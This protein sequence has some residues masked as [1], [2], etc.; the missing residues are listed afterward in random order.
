MSRKKHS[1]GTEN[2]QLITCADKMSEIETYTLPEESD[3]GFHKRSTRFA[4][5]DFLCLHSYLHLVIWK[6][7]PARNAGVR[8]KASVRL[9]DLVNRDTSA[10]L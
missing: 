4:M 10:A 6:A 9:Y 7:L 5:R 3:I 8:R 2:V 1:G